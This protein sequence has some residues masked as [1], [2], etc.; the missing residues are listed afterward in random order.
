MSTYNIPFEYEKKKKKKKKKF[1]LNYPK[2]AA[3]DFSKRLNNKFKIAVVNEPSVFEPLN[4]YCIYF[5]VHD[6]DADI[7]M[8]WLEGEVDPT[9][10]L[11]FI[12]DSLLLGLLVLQNPLQR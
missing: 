5:P 10:R 4:V 6:L 7:K 2:P 12:S 8:F 11:I 3:M 9:F 1:T